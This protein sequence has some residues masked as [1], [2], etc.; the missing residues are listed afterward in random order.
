MPGETNLQKLLGSMSPELAAR[1]IRL[2]HALARHA[3]AGGCPPRHG[4]PRA[5]GRHADPPRG[6]GEGGRPRFRVPQ[7][8]DHAERPFLAGRRVGFLA[9]ITARLAAAG[10]GV[11]PV[12]AYFHDHLFIPADRAGEAMTILEALAAENRG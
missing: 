9:A 10:M 12:S 4:L 1:R 2:R 3:A 7:P 11:N 5:R 8:H 6:R